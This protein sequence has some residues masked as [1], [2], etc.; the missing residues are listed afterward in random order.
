MTI[1]NPWELYSSHAGCAEANRLLDATWEY[2]RTM[3]MAGAAE[4]F[5]LA[6]LENLSYMGAMDSEPRAILRD[7]LTDEYGKEKF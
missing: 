4:L 6:Q 7:K 1:Y 3:K 5:M 2:A